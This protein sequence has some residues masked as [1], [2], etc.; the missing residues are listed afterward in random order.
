MYKT[1]ITELLNIKYPIIEG[2]MVWAGGENLALAVSKNG[3]LGT[4]AGGSCLSEN[5]LQN[6][7]DFV[8]NNTNKPYAINIPMIYPHADM[9]A[10]ITLKNKVPVVITSAGNPNKYTSLFKKAGIK[11]LHVVANEKFAIKSQEAGVDAVIA[12]GVEAGGHNGQDE[13]TSL[14]MIPNIV[15]K[16][17]IPIIAA[18]GI[19]TGE[20]ILAMLV[21][22]ASAVQLGTIFAASKESDSH[23][24]YKKEII[25][26][27]D[28]ST[29]LTGRR[30]SPVRALKNEFSKKILMWEYSSLTNEEILKKIGTGGSYRG[31]IEGDI[32]NGTPLAGQSSVLVNEL[33]SVDE[34]F[35]KL[36][37]EFNN[38]LDKIRINL[39]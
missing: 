25:Q 10:E 28:N 12:E 35:Y 38:S 6:K 39:M 23:L 17:N 8:K 14:V 16:L 13:L 7:I 3:G 18:G 37:K 21:L 30:L 34:I 9:L 32:I 27:G 31:I 26:S 36:L 20:Q 22:G 4:I 33:L 24:N 11:V 19:A 29:I 5:D 2:G 15:K 1:K